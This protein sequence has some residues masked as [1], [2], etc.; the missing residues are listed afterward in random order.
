MEK[1]IC[2]NYNL[3]FLGFRGTFGAYN[4]PVNDLLRRQKN[5][6]HKIIECALR[7]FGGNPVTR[8]GSL[9]MMAS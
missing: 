8:G 4:P 5:H 9:V 7:D 1:M 2:K 6:G 3:P